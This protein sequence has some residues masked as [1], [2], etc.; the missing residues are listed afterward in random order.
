MDFVCSYGE[1][2]V[3]CDEHGHEFA[4]MLT[5]G[6]EDWRGSYTTFRVVDMASLR[7]AA[8]DAGEPR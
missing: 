7:A 4:F 2:A 5:T 8:E 3:L 6:E 1:K